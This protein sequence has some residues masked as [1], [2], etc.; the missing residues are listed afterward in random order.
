MTYAVIFEEGECIYG[1][2]AKNK[3]AGEFLLFIV[4]YV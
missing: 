4:T 3:K 2:F 1:V